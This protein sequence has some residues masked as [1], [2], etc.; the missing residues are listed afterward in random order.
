MD[1]TIKDKNGATLHTAEKYCEEDIQVNID[2]KQIIINPSEEQQIQEGLFGEIIVPA[3]T[4]E[5]DE[6]IKSENI[7]EG[8]TILGV[9]GGFKGVDS[10]NA[11]ATAKDMLRNK[12]A[13]INNKEVQG[14]IETYDGG[15]FGEATV[16]NEWEEI[17]KSCIDTTYGANITKLPKGITAI[18]NYAFNY[19]SNLA[20][21]D[22]S[23]MSFPT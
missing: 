7:I 8:V 20:L 13:Y 14:E 18:R 17:L 10:S 4:A 11:T 2:A 6:D 15:Y 19:C 23:I 3:V 21:T 1:I 5:I 16:G 12:T 9:K 22:A